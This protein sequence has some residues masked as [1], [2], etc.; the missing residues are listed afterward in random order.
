MH[1]DHHSHQETSIKTTWARLVFVGI[2]VIF[3]YGISREAAYQW[4][5]VQHHTEVQNKLLDYIGE[6][7][8]ALRRFYHLPYLLTNHPDTLAIV[9]GEQHDPAAFQAKLTQLDKAANTEGWTLLS[10]S[11]DVLAS[12]L[13]D[14]RFS[15]PD[16]LAIVE[17]VLHQGEGVSLVN[18]TKGYGPLY[19]LSAPVF[20]GLNIAAIVVVQIDLS[21]LTEQPITS[22]DIILL[23]NRQQRFF[24]SSSSEYNADWLNA[25]QLNAVQQNALQQNATQTPEHDKTRTVNRE[26]RYLYNSTA[27]SQWRL[28]ATSFLGHT[29]KL[30]DLKWS[31]S[32][33][34]PYKPIKG[35]ASLFA[36][37]VA[38]ALLVVILLLIIGQQRRQ[39]HR[40]QQRIQSLLQESQRR[41][42]QMIDKTQVGLLLI[43][44]QGALF[45]L[46]PMAKR[47]FGLP[48]NN[49][50]RIFAWELFDTGNPHS[51]TLTLLK[52]LDQHNELAE[53]NAVETMARRSDGSVFPALFS[54]TRF[55]W[56]DEQYYLATL[57]DIS[58]RKKAEQSLQQMNQALTERVEER[59]QA[60]QQA[61]AQLI[62]TSKMAAL[63]RMSS[64]ITHELNQPLTG[65]RT[66]LTT[67]TLLAERGET[68]KVK[69]NN[70]LV[71]K[72]IDRMTNMTS[73]LKT[74]AYSKPQH[75]HPVSLADALNETL[76]VYQAQLAD[77]D[78]RVRMPHDTPLI[79]GEGQRLLQIL[80]N[81]VSNACDA[82]ANT[83]APTLVFVVTPAERTVEL[84]VSDNGCGASTDVLETMFEPFVTSKKIGDGLGLGLA[85]TA[86]NVRDINGQIS[87]APNAQSGLTFTLTFQSV[88][89]GH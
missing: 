66:L 3:S 19:Y 46:N 27:T 84:T 26:T 17:Q 76:R 41:L 31:V 65:L 53:L 4:L 87:V 16:R 68:E 51:T 54:L 63:G 28:N 20:E 60:L 82:M 29:V 10:T 77:I 5:S 7:R 38:A 6:V 57:I 8:R 58:K 55:P 18:K 36:W 70:Q 56:H 71:Q 14:E 67:N 34:T 47:L 81:L 2:L 72:L 89:P 78:V 22:Q 88:I 62:E 73:Q 50:H 21:F 59:T 44:Q 12:S 52:N 37:G 25:A 30:D 1:Q 13:I 79:E 74:F 40:H 15:R 86:N 35:A 61:Q 75:L 23:Q 39:K 11:G 42:K 32:Y 49:H 83:A 80:G 24:L 85:I 45:D 48:E 9:K 43:D 33:L 69:A 64:A